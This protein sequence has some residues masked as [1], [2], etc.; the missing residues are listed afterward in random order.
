MRV[1]PYFVSNLAGSLNQTQATEQQLTAELSSG[2]RVT[3]LSQDPLASGEN[4]LLLNQIQQD[5]SFTQS[6]SLVK[7]QLQVADSALGSVVTQ[8]TQAI[9]LATGANNGT[10]NSSN[11]KGIANQIS[12]ILYEVQSLANTSYQGQYIFGG[13]QSSNAPFSTSNA[14][15]PA[16]TSYSGDQ[17]INYL[18]MPN[19]QKIQLNVPGDQIFSGSGT[20]SVFGALNNLVADYS[21]GTVDTNKAVTDTQSLNTALNYVSQQRV[22]I[23]NSITHLTAASDAAGS[24]QAQ[25]TMAQTNLMQADVA[26]LSTQL[27]LA[28]TQQTALESVIA[29]LGSVS[30]S[31][32]SKL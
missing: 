8:L 7:G 15:S 2:V 28:E 24:E 1:D 23:D 25:L 29:Q 9:S 20:N 10:M 18:Q 14:L 26:H 31:L 30:N 12:G 13:G 32:F 6:T 4:V 27:S 21:S 11:L 17:N 5:D 16:V 22:T 19:G 3:S